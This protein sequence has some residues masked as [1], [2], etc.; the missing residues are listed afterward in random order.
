MAD[1]EDDKDNGDMETQGDGDHR[2][3]PCDPVES[4]QLGGKVIFVVDFVAF[5][6]AN[7]HCFVWRLQHP[8]L[9]DNTFFLHLV[10]QE[11]NI[12][13]NMILIRKEGKNIR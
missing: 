10:D 8:P 6:V 9:G 12:I 11:Q 3:T 5:Q 13:Q 4:G 2:S 7:D 1:N